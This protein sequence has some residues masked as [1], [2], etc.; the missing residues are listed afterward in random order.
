MYPLNAILIGDD[1]KLFRDV[2]RE[3]MNCSC[4][5]DA[6]YADVQKAIVALRSS[7]GAK[8]LVVLHLASP[9]EL[10]GLS[11]LNTS[12]PGWP[13]L[14]LMDQ[15]AHSNGSRGEII[16]GVMRAG[17]SQIVS[18]PLQ[19]RDFKDVL[20]RIA[21]QFAQARKESKV[22]AVAGATGG[23]GATIIAINLA[24]E[25]A[26][27]HGLR[28]VLADLSLRM[29]AVACHLNIEPTNTILDLIRDV[30][31]VDAVLVEQAL[32]KVADNF[33]I[34]AGPNEFVAPSATSI[35]DVAH[36]VD[37]LKQ[38][39]AV[40]VLDIPCTYDDFYFHTLASAGQV[41]LIGEQK[42]P[43]VRAL[44]MVHER[45][46]RASGTE[47]LVINRFDAKNSGFGVDRLLKPLGVSKLYT[48][49]R[50]DVAMSAAVDGGDLLRRAAPRSPC[51]TDIANLAKA[52]LNLDS[53]APAKPPGLFGRL[54]RAFANK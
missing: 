6:E 36:V 46:G 12:L 22:I 34:L 39:A 31:R 32:T 40:V 44:R 47:F 26:S 14:V 50:D 15:D 24:F 41:V 3:L 2:R 20:D 49:A 30:S 51:V 45:L 29:G 8:R 23:C 4:Q 28:C 10:D 16:I 13:V 35:Q 19:P 42:L 5:L 53:A 21:L 48:V 9:P 25:I 54:G 7:A 37:V 43:A 52:L 18:L 38:I 33:Q 17:A 1:E 11:R 27:Q